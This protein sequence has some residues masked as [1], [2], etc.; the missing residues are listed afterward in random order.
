VSDLVYLVRHGDVV[1][2]E[3]RR[4]VGHLDLPLSLTGERQLRAL[5]HRLA[6]AHLEAVYSSDLARSRR[7]AEIL[8][9][10]HRLVPVPVPELREFAMG[11][12]DGL[13]AEQIRERDPD[14]FEEWMSR[15]GEFQFPGG[16][17]LTQV[18][19]RAWGAFQRIVEAHRGP[20]AVVAHGGPNRAVLCRALGID[21]ARILSL[22]QDYGSISV[23]AR[24]GGGWRLT[25]LNHV[26]PIG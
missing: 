2:S 21:V 14:A 17:N 3:T 4:F 10:I 19:A 13:T 8:A 12:W 18:T 11:R 6:A 16:E 26:E 23:L 24:A 5:A 9:E 22:G 25:V 15:I 7:S 1:G 20:V